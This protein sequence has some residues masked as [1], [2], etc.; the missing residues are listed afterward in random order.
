MLTLAALLLQL[1]VPADAYADSATRAFVIEARAAR[2]RNERLVTSYRVRA[3][4]RLGI[5]IR[6]LTR[7][8]M[9]W[10]QELVAD[11]HWRRDSVS[12]ATVVGAREAAP[13]A[14]RGDNLPSSLRGDVRELIIDP[15][16]DFLKVIGADDDEGFLYPLRAG[17]EQDYRFAL[18][19]LTEIGLPDGR[20]VRLVALRVTPRRADW[21]LMNGTLWFDADTRGLVRAA[22][23]PARPYELQRDLDPEDRDDVPGWVNVRAEVRFVTLEYGLYESRWWMPRYVAID[24]VG[25]MGSWMNAPFKLER[26]YEDY[27]VEGGIPPDADSDFVPAGRSQWVRRD[28]TPVDSA[29]RAHVGD[30]VR[31]VLRECLRAARDRGD[32]VST[33]DTPSGVD[34]CR[35]D[36]EP[37]NLTVHV[38]GDTLALLT[39]PELGEPILTMGDLITED[40]LVALR[41]AI[42]GIPD[43]PWETHVELPRGVGALLRNARYNRIEAL[44]LGARGAIDFGRLRLDGV[45]RIG[46]ADGEP[47]AELTLV[48]ETPTRRY[49]IGAYRRLAAANPEDSPLGVMNSVT[50]FVFGRDDGHYFRTRGVEFIARDP[51]LGRWEL[52]L[53]HE[54]QREALVETDF[55]IPG[56]W[57]D[58][59]LFRT[60]FL[61]D[62]ATQTGASVT[63]RAA[64]PVSRTVTLSSDVSLE[65]A[66][67]DF[68]FERGSVTLRAMVV[69][70]ASKFA[71]ALSLTAA[72]SQGAVPAQSLFR[73]GGPTSIR[74]YP[75]AALIG[76]GA[77]VAR[78]EVSRGLPAA[79]LVAFADVGWAG[80]RA[81][82]G[83]GRTL[84][85]VGIGASILDGLVRF[86]IARGLNDPKGTRLEIYVDGLL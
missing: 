43:R 85:G 3:S 64:H 38:P 26:I 58:N 27:E 20:R 86:D 34:N 57:N 72:T 23:R 21:R 30:S 81:H 56:L 84:V 61:A 74:G 24:A 65:A 40:E 35:Q 39:A 48:R 62:H 36:A 8:R 32:T 22:F 19:D 67:G 63:L 79:R 2:E 76:T 66:R 6:A 29:T 54:R 41:D 37:D 15:A 17:S 7:D 12:T 10:R 75:T 69:P 25:S 83:S 28:G 80:D 4:Q 44:S 73:V 68:D 59:R 53:Y 51:G 46:V 55:S 49:A 16:S 71:G 1:Q 14:V 82:W 47:N 18:G 52:R 50:T 42:E 33:P 77:W 9:L 13:I 78:G 45:A 11:I 31:T 5:G 60:N 70:V